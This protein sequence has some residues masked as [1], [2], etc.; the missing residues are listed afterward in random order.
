MGA[1]ELAL[2]EMESGVQARHAVGDN[3]ITSGRV[4]A[5]LSPQ[6][7]VCAVSGTR[8]RRR[9]IGIPQVVEVKTSSERSPVVP[10]TIG[11]VRQRRPACPQRMCGPPQAW[12]AVG[13]PLG[14]G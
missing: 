7:I 8:V 11:W 14:P 12:S 6:C 1:A 9:R 4:A 5:A 13:G 3:A 10:G 2:V